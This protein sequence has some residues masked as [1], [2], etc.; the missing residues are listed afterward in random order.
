MARNSLNATA[1][2]YFIAA[3]VDG[4]KTRAELCAVSGL[5]QNLVSRLIKALQARGVLY[6]SAWATDHRGYL[7]VR[8]YSLGKGTDVLCPKKPRAEVVRDWIAKKRQRAA[9]KTE[10]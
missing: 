5:S 8:V 9:I 4:P 6:V 3:L 7:T 10:T 1:Y 2:S